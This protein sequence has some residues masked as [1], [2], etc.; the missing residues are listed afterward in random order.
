M[1]YALMWL[2]CNIYIYIYIYFYDEIGSF[3]MSLSLCPQIAP[4]S[5]HCHWG[6]FD[7]KI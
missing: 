7:G 4:C 6:Y 3:C 2:E 1:K 5:L